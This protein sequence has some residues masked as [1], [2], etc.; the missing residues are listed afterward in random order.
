MSGRAAAESRD[1]TATECGR[2]ESVKHSN[3]LQ[4]SHCNCR[5]PR[6]YGCMVW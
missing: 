6:C 3:T 5:E 2:Y 4:H 1:A